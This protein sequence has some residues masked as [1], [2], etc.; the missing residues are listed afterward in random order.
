MI[1]RELLLILKTNNYLRAI[2][3]RLGNP[4]NTY[5]TINNATW[6]VFTNEMIHDSKWE[7]YSEC[8]R[9]YFLK[10]MLSMNLWKI[11]LMSMFGIKASLEEMKDFDLDYNE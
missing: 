5:N 10:L 6:R 2:D 11:K 4:T 8:F 1:K 7:F 9:Y 3:K